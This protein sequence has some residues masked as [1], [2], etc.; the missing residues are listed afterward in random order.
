[1]SA[2]PTQSE[3][4]RRAVAYGV[5]RAAGCLNKGPF[6]ETLKPVLKKARKTSKRC[7]ASPSLI[8]IL[9]S[10]LQA[11]LVETQQQKPA[12]KEDSEEKE[13]A[14]FFRGALERSPQKLRRRTSAPNTNR[15]L[16]APRSQS[17]RDQLITHPEL[18]SGGL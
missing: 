12:S 17:E 6:S 15:P 16:F 5:L 7:L 14:P 2:Q 4:V 9:S 8:Q 10:P 11:E 13:Q 3:L 1:M 18:P